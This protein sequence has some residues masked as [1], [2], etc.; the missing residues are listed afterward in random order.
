MAGSTSA[1]SSS[2]STRADVGDARPRRAAGCAGAR[3][4]AGSGATPRSAVSRVSSIDSQVSSSSRSRESS[5]EQPAAEGALRAGEPLAQPD[6]PRGGALGPLER[7]GGGR[8][9]D[10]RGRRL[11]DVDV[12]AGLGLGRGDDVG[13]AA[14]DGRGYD[15][16]G[17]QQPGHQGDRHDGDADDQARASHQ[18]CGNPTRGGA[19]ARFAERHA[20]TSAA[21]APPTAA[22][23]AARTGQLVTGSGRRPR[24][25]S[26]G[27]R[28]TCA[29]R[30]RA[31]G[32]TGSRSPRWG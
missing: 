16:A 27:R 8:G 14:L 26:A 9:L 12:R 31:T 18:P 11:G 20:G 4:A 6:Q 29:S 5:A 10:G 25:A 24:E 3:R 17:R 7:R 22:R 32:T 19:A 23:L 30:R 1:T 13:A 2:R 15:G 21:A 28:R